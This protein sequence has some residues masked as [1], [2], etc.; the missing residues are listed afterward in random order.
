MAVVAGQFSEVNKNL[1][2]LLFHKGEK[3]PMARIVSILRGG[4]NMNWWICGDCGSRFGDGYCLNRHIRFHTI[5][6]SCSVKYI[7]IYDYWGEWT[8]NEYYQNALVP[9][10]EYFVDYQYWKQV[11]TCNFPSITK[12]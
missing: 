4:K 3:E 12:L 9:I 11:T 8:R 6:E 5:C 2:L 7:C 10:S 1:I